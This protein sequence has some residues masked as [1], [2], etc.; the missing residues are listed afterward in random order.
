[1]EIGHPADNS[2]VRNLLEEGKLEEGDESEE[3]E[4]M[5]LEEKT[6]ESRTIRREQGAIKVH[7]R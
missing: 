3:G 7:D 1:M 6:Y 5:I 2:P 4:G